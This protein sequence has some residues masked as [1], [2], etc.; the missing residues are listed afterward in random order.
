MGYKVVRSKGCGVPTSG[1]GGDTC[2]YLS[3]LPHRGVRGV[4][5]G[6]VCWVWEERGGVGVPPTYLQALHVPGVGSV[7]V[8]P[9]GVHALFDLDLC[10][11]V[12][13][14]DAV[15]FLQTAPQM[16]DEATANVRAQ[17]T[18]GAVVM[19]GGGDTGT[20]CDAQMD[21]VTWGNK[22]R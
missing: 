8:D 17:T 16:V 11:L 22:G 15:S 10:V 6:V 7:G 20:W 13:R 21:L 12:L 9:H 4:G 14:V 2:G 1:G 19:S 5:C 3:A 18:H